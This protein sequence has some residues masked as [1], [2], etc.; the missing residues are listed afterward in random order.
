MSAV[1][2][3]SAA[4]VVNLAA[5]S[6]SEAVVLPIAEVIKAAELRAGGYRNSDIDAVSDLKIGW[7]ESDASHRDSGW[8][9]TI[10]GRELMLS[11]QAV[12]GASKMIGQHNPK[13][14]RMYPDKDAFPKA[15]EHILVNPAMVGNRKNA[16]R[17]LIRDDGIHIRAILPQTYK[18]MDAAQALDIFTTQI[19]QNVGTIQGI[20]TLMDGDAGDLMSYRIVMDTN[21][22]PSLAREHGQFMMFML[23]ISETGASFKGATCLTSIGSFRTS[24]TN[25]A[26]RDATTSKWN[27]RVSGEDRFFGDT[28]ERIR[29]MGYYQ[30]RYTAIFNE[31]LN[32]KLDNTVQPRD[33]LR[34]FH[35]EKLI[36][37]GHF[38]AAEMYI[39]EK[40][41]DGRK[42]E[43]QYDLF[44][45][46][47]RAAHDLESLVA[48]QTA[49]T[50]TLHLFTEKG[51]IYERL[52]NAATDR[53]REI[54]MRRG[55]QLEI[56]D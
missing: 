13:H 56:T 9:G 10:H 23:A 52:R 53:A 29:Q 32:A 17:L 46:L 51:G 49:E 25:S 30:D 40:T 44:N 55:T 33:I 38:D 6:S 47:T 35:Q 3:K 31:L 4:K 20:S 37:S 14:W 39:R 24:C 19:K 16:K 54:A 45:V 21:I 26:V 22:M 48:R 11:D 2:E 50:R 15:L 8:Y 41:E 43:T 1:T 7:R 18:I 42:V 27:H 12:R 34:A 36:T 28:N 5:H